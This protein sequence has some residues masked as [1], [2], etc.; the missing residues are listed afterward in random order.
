MYLSLLRNLCLEDVAKLTTNKNNRL[1]V[2][3]ANP[4]ETVKEEYRINM[5]SLASKEFVPKTF[6]P[7]M[8]SDILSEG[9]LENL[10]TEGF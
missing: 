3:T 1:G 5:L 6:S 8:L 7:A 2:R 4:V 9:K 10:L